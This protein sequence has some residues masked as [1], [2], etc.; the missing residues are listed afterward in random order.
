MARLTIKKNGKG[1]D[2]GTM[3]S[4]PLTLARDLDFLDK[5]LTI[6]KHKDGILIKKKDIE[7]K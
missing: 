2:S 4:I 1:Y 7:N 5:E 6:E 3:I